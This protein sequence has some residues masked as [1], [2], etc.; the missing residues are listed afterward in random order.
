MQLNGTFLFTFYFKFLLIS[1]DKALQIDSNIFQA[2][3]TKGDS[4]DR[5]G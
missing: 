4:F 3:Q 1:S 2:W 5:L